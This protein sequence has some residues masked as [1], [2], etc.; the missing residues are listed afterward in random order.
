MTA[1]IIPP[2]IVQSVYGNA[3]K[4]HTQQQSFYEDA[5]PQQDDRQRELEADLQ[6]L[7]DAQSEA[8]EAVTRNGAIDDGASTGSTT[9]TARSIR[10]LPAR[11]RPARRKPGIKSARKG[12]WSTMT[13]LSALKD[14]ELQ[15]ID[16]EARDKEQALEQI[17]A[18]EKKRQGLMEASQDVDD[19]TETVRA[20]RLRQEADVLGEEIHSVELQLAD[21]K[22]RH[23]K[24][25]RQVAAAEN[26][27]QAK[28]ASYKSSMSMLEADIQAFL[29]LE[30]KGDAA[31]HQP[32]D[33][34]ASMWQLPAKRRTLEMA[35]QQWQRDR[36]AVLKQRTSVEHE[37]VALDE[38][39]AMWQ[40][41]VVQITTYERHV[42]AA[43][44]ANAKTSPGTGTDAHQENNGHQDLAG[45]AHEIDSV[46]ENLEAKSAIAQDRHWN[47]LIAAIG[48][49]LEALRQA[50]K[51][52]GGSHVE[53]EQDKLVDA[54][55]SAGA[56][57][58]LSAGQ[59]IHELDR[60]F[61][62]AKRRPISNG[63]SASDDEPD[64]EL[65]F[66]SH[67][68]DVG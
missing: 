22:A 16:A 2:P 49:E 20:Q 5:T 6:F 36:E 64:P 25:L 34:K 31:L 62:T 44:V 65:L 61:E 14:E 51:L 48:A 42:R 11:P 35:K 60:S 46:I 43:L 47:L 52:F 19:N 21:M 4:L 63:S 7:L 56:E 18:W 17:D 12:I 45:L 53:D 41:A 37:K 38:G 68:S 33:G 24:L 13:A 39:A 30:P 55:D 15:G 10:S 26:S 40:D 8:L 1:S 50:K 54:G 32:E 28:L 58:A 57:S 23:R 3:S 27:V 9:P 59:E 67:D 29:S 66:S